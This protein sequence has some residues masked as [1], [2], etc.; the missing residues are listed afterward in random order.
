MS[1]YPDEQIRN[2]AHQLREKAGRPEDKA[3]EFWRQA[4]IGLDAE[5][6]SDDPS[7]QPNASTIP[8]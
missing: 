3:D 5:G 1:R 7:D 8:G 2:Y 4:E 6:E